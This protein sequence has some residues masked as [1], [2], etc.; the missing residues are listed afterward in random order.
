FRRVG[1]VG[2]T[3][4]AGGIENG[5][6]LGGSAGFGVAT[7]HTVV[8]KTSA[9]GVKRRVPFVERRE[10]VVERLHRHSGGTAQFL[11]PS[12]E[13]RGLVHDQRL[14]GPEGR[15]NARFDTGLV[16]LL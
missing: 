16:D 15:I 7:F 3:T 13:G 5:L 12:V 11:Q 9:N 4:R 1:R 2:R 10:K 6:G 14:V 8:G